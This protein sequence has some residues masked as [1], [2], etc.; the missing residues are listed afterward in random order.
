MYILSYFLGQL[1][2]FAT[3]CAIFNITNSLQRLKPSLLYI[4]N[5]KLLT[6]LLT[7]T[8][9]I[10]IHYN[11]LVHPYL[12]ADNRHYIFYVWNRLYGR[13]VWFKYAAAPI[14]ILSIFLIKSGLSHLRDSYK[15]MFWLAVILSL[16]PQRLLELRYFLIPFVLFRLNTMPKTKS[17][18]YQWLELAAY[19]AINALTFY[20][21]FTKEIKWTNFKEPQ[22]IIW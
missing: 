11:T 13:Y 20:I 1:F 12:L 19:V 3:F 9:L 10:I 14:Y 8:F 22:R 17:Y 15:L 2:Y 21:F 6:I 4:K 5:H 18:L 7:A 16:C